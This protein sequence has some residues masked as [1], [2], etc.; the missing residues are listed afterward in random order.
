MK[1]ILIAS[2]L[3]ISVK[4]VGQGIDAELYQYNY[5]FI[6][7]AFAG[8][9]GQRIS[10]LANTADY[11]QQFGDGK[12]N[13]RVLVSYENY[14]EKLNSGFA[15]TG[16]SERFAT[17]S[18][19]SF[20]FSYNYKVKLGTT[21]Y[22][23]AGGR[24][25]RHFYSISSDYYRVIDPSDPL[26]D[27]DFSQ[28]NWTADAGLLLRVSQFYFGLVASNLI[29]THNQIDA[30]PSSVTIDNHEAG[31]VGASFTISDHLVS[32]HSL[33]IPIEKK[34]G[35]MRGIDYRIDLNNTLTINDLFLAGLSIE[36]SNDKFFAKFNAGIKVKDY[37]QIL[38]L[39]YSGKRNEFTDPKFRGEM[40]IG[41]RF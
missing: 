17:S 6:H 40:F 3:L 13:T 9:E 23:V 21:S 31:I 11:D 30:I 34:K 32:N 7:P 1:K 19:S 25:G 24:T 18:L 10:V 16:Y 22:L 8:S 26:L 5:S 12:P 35:N 38:F 29:H 15:I 41:L 20:S 37:F 2:L 33:Y 27:R 39:L 14:F 4:A 36:R 28:A